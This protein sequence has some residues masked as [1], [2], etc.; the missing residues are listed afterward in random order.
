MKLIPLGSAETENAT[1]A[2]DDCM[3][4]VPGRFVPGT[5]VSAVVEG[6]RVWGEVGV[7]RGGL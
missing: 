1:P 5:R 4:R 2:Y 6:F 3:I 7:E